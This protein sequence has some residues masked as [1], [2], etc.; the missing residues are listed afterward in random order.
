MFTK[1]ELQFIFQA[2]NQISYK[3]IETAGYL[4]KLSA[5]VAAEIKKFEEPEK[6]DKTS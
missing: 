6:K 4:F 3:G 2:L 5:K 1:E